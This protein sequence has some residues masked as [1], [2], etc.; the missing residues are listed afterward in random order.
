MEKCDDMEKLLFR[1]SPIHGTGGFACIDISS[2]VR[3]IEYVGEK[4]TKQESLA[5]CEQNNEYIFALSDECDLDGNV[6]WNPARFLNHS[7][8][9]NCEARLEDGRIWVMTICDVRAGEEL[10][11]NY[12]YDLESYREHPCRC[13]APKCVGYIV[14]EEFL[15]DVRR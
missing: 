14:A 5:R 7:C 2:G 4:I 10:T 15:D 1:A 6:S 12:G 9:P 13:G 3:V 8:A 11:F